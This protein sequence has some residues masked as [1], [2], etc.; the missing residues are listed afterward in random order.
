MSLAPR[1]IVEWLF[2]NKFRV[3]F[4]PANGDDKGPKGLEGKG[5]TTR[6]YAI[7]EYTDA[8]RVGIMTGTELVSG[9]YFHDVDIDWANGADIAVALLP[10]TDFIYGRPSKR[11]SHCGYLSQT[12]M[13]SKRYED[14]ITKE[15]LLELRG[16]QAD[17]TLGL[18]SMCPPS[19]WSK[20]G[21]TEP[22]TFSRMRMPTFVEDKAL[23]RRVAIAATSVLLA[24]HFGVNGYGHEPRLALS[25]FLLSMDITR[26][27]CV[28]I[29][30]AISHYCNNTETHDVAQ[31]VDS[32]KKRLDADKKAR[33]AGSLIKIFGDNGRAIVQR[34]R[35]WFGFDDDFARNRTH[36]IIADHQGNITR[37]IRLINV[38]LSYNEFSD[39]ML[40]TRHNRTAP[41]EDRELTELWLAIDDEFR[42]RA[43]FYFFEKVV[44]RLAWSQAFHP[45]RMYLD[46]L[47]WDGVPRIDT[48][49]QIAG[50]AKPSPYM[51]AVSAIVLIAA[52]R[53]IRHPG[54]KHDE[55]L[56]LESGQGLHKSSALRTLCPEQSW[57]S[58]D[59]PLNV[60]AQQVIECTLG[61][62]IIEAS[63][64]SGMRPAQIE[65]LKSNVSRQIDGP[66]R[67][68]YAHL[69]IER[70]RQFV[71][72][73][74]TNSASYL[75][76]PTGGRRFWPV[77]VKQ[78][79]VKWIA[80]HRD[81]LWAEA[82]HREARGESNRLPEHLWSEAAK[83]QE[84]R[85]EIDPW[86]PEIRKLLHESTSLHAYDDART[87]VPTSIIWDSL[88]I[89]K[90]RR[91]RR[92]SMRIS[93]IMQRLEF[94]RTPVRPPG[95]PPQA[96]YVSAV[97]HWLRYEPHADDTHDVVYDLT[98]S[99]PPITEGF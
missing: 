20:E 43:T 35:E 74:T 66:A 16:T 79:D 84:Q 36:T 68:A 63:E 11:V 82:S 62:W 56:V 53:R 55:I 60:G 95:E 46:A 59:F 1:T 93:D 7:D 69:P 17:G 18:Q 39:K 4:W 10:K 13:P 22:L 94:T 8:K 51:S 52:V 70:P 73:G 38:Q 26:D 19:I 76:D 47:Q 65:E 23:A 2:A 5:W 99:R 97:A 61:K 15:C 41:L 75:A 86:E 37:A 6:A 30:I 40:V 90:E 24:K 81:Q 42:F 49:L 96:G 57:F 12:A 44:K 34:I 9:Q 45:V 92:G 78:F 50:G 3:V 54:C 29:G 83:H 25:G 71:V 91:D 80:A 85:R 21:N 87:R 98:D 28:E 48:W 31:A 72:I 32:T 58:D 64:L 88:G 14:P 33:G 27:E 67:M 89:P 77:A